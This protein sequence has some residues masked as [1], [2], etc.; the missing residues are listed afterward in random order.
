MMSRPDM[1]NQ[2]LQPTATR[3]YARVSAAELYRWAFYFIFA[4]TSIFRFSLSQA[5]GFI[6]RAFRPMIFVF[7]RF[8]TRALIVHD[9]A[10]DF[11]DGRP[12]TPNPALQPTATRGYATAVCN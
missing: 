9:C 3:A 7:E 11:C 8:A 6:S 4:A 12:F 5:I 2:A 10:D 1:P